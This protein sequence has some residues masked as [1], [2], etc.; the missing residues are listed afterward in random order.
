MLHLAKSVTAEY[1]DVLSG[2]EIDE[3]LLTQLSFQA[4]G[5]LPAMTALFG[6]MAAQEVL[7]GCSGKFGPIRQWVYFDSLESLPKDVALTEQ[8]VAP[9][10]SRYDRQV[11]VFGKEFTEKI[12]A[13]KTFLVGSGAIG[14]RCLRTGLSWV[15]ERTE[16]ST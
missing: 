2:G 4:A 9:T 10:G 13:V 7:K 8:S 5:E 15:L 6:G 14:C 11:A 16:R 12:F 3:K 1:P